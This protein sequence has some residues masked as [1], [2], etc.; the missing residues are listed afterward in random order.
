MTEQHPKILGLLSERNCQSKG[1]FDDLTNVRFW[2]VPAIASP[3]VTDRLWPIVRI[4]RG[5]RKPTVEISLDGST[6][7]QHRPPKAAPAKQR[8]LNQSAQMFA[9]STLANKSA[10]R[11][12]RSRTWHCSRLQGQQKVVRAVL[13]DA[14]AD[15]LAKIVDCRSSYE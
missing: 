11:R 6:A 13:S 10:L 5:A 3:Q 9:Y 1:G 12:H 7:F 4:Q 2:F 15:N 14:S 8:H